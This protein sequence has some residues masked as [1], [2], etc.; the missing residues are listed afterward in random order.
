MG[1]FHSFA[2][3]VAEK[4]G[5]WRQWTTKRHRG[6][7]HGMGELKMISE[8][9]AGAGKTRKPQKRAQN[10]ILLLT[11]RLLAVAEKRKFWKQ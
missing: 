5:F 6:F 2:L 4:E 8:R 7:V 3:P 10:S 9:T 11:K 1:K